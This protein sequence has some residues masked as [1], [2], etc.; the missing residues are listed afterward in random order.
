VIFNLTTFT[1]IHV[2]LSL[3]GIFAGLVVVGGLL[4]GARLDGWTGLFLVTTALTSITGFGF[5]FVSFLPSHGVGIISLVLLPIVIVARYRKQLTGAWRRVYVVGT[6]LVLYLNVFVLV[7]QLFRRLPALIVAAPTQKEPPFLITQ[8][9]IMAL[10]VALGIAAVK[11]F[12]V[13]A[14]ASLSL[15][16][17]LWGRPDL[18]AQDPAPAA[19]S[20]I[21]LSMPDG[22]RM[23]P[24]FHP[25]D[26][27][28]EVK[29]GTLLIGMGN[30]LD[31]NKTLPLAVGDTVVAPAGFHH[32]SIARGATVVSVTFIG[33]YTITYVNTCEAP[34][35]GP[36]PF[37][38]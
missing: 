37:G 5:P 12:R 20:T 21:Q 15:A 14:V 25:T 27:R 26:E 8:L 9:L 19:R 7:V 3:V 29:Q 36:F 38:Y 24:H 10:F 13:A 35:Q 30:R 16:A 1:L 32:Y 22:Y 11:R 2:V 33:P 31:V 18:A 28:V 6:V 17:L 23:P 4:A 34:R